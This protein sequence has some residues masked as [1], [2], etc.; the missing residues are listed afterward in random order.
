MRSDG[1]IDLISSNNT[2]LK[3]F[4]IFNQILIFL[5]NLKNT[6]YTAQAAALSK[7]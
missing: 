1:K 2:Y 7:R 3:N 5:F 6:E 4:D